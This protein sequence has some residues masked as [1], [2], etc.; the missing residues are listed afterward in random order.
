M[1]VVSTWAQSDT[2]PFCCCHAPPLPPPGPGHAEDTLLNIAVVVKPVVP[3]RPPFDVW[4]EL[5]AQSPSG[6]ISSY[7]DYG[8]PAEAVYSPTAAA[9][10]T[11]AEAPA[12]AA[13][14]SEDIDAGLAALLADL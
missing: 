8:L 7:T 13:E 11:A 6:H 12:A 4:E 9:A 10:P 5:M 1:C 3:Y 2:T 14:E